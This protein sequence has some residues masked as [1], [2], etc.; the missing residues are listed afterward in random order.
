MQKRKAVLLISAFFAVTLLISSCASSSKEKVPSE[1]KT[2]AAQKKSSE[3]KGSGAK[4]S[5]EVDSFEAVT[6]RVPDRPVNSYF[7]S[8]NPEIVSLVETGSPESLREAVSLLHKAGSEEYSDAEKILLNICSELMKICWSSQSVSWEIPEITESNPY[9]GAVESARNGIYD[10]ST[11]NTD[12][13]TIA[14]PSLVLLTSDSRSDYYGASEDALLKALDLNV[15]SVLANYLMGHLRRRQKMFKE[16]IAFFNRCANVT[17]LCFEINYYK[18][19]S[20]LDS[21]DSAQALEIGERLLSSNSQN[22]NLLQ[23]CAEASYAQGNASNTEMYVSRVLQLEPENSRYVLFRVRLLVNRGDYIKASSLLDV[24]S[25][26]NQ[27]DREYL[28]LRAKLQKD[29]NKN[30]T[31][32]ISTMTQALALYPDDTEVIAFAARIASEANQSINGMSAYELADRILADDS[33]NLEALVISVNEM[34]K[35]NEWQKAYDL[36]KSLLGRSDCPKQMFSTHI[37]ICLSL[38]KNDEADQLATRL[39]K[40]NPQ[41]ESIQEQYICMLVSFDRKTEG[42]ALIQSLLPASNSRMK[43]FLLYEKSFFETSENAALNDL[44][45][46]LTANPRNKEALFRLYEIYYDRSDWRKAQYYLK[47]VVALNPSDRELLRLNAE[48]EQF[49]GN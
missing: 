13:L 22:V 31:A 14:L 9:T 8:I 36:S 25:R 38:K 29:W 28:L 2:S 3:K 35:Q 16:S 19:L 18:A 6:L 45:S 20:C 39:Y 4:D 32:A 48:L 49:I 5:I 33:S 44:R 43:S 17:P 30:N 23:L 34:T 12:F 26:T 10:S 37:S 47:Q 24:Y 27:T 42:L 1:E 7:T 11:G 40:E 46:S 15:N 41:D 21:G